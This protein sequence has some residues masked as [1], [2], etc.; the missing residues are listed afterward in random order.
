MKSNNS[1]TALDIQLCKD[2]IGNKYTLVCFNHYFIIRNMTCMLNLHGFL[3]CSDIILLSKF[4][5]S[6]GGIIYQEV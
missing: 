4:N 1:R 5:Q 3:K 6:K 2:R